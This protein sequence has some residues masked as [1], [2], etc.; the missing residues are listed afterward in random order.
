MGRRVRALGPIL[1]LV[2]VAAG[3]CTDAPT[4]SEAAWE[5]VPL[6]GPGR[7]VTLTGTPE[8]LL[9]GRYDEDAR[10]RASLHE[11]RADGSSGQVEMDT[12]WEWAGREAEL[13]SV[14]SGP[15]GTVA[16]G[17]HRAGAHGNVRWTVWSGDRRRV[18]EQPQPFETFGGWDAGGL[19][20]VAISRPGPMIL[21][22]RVSTSKQGLD[23]AVWQP[24]GE[25]WVMAPRP[26]STLRATADRQPSPGAVA[27][28][29][30]GY[31]AVGWVTELEP[32]IR[33]VAVAWTARSPGGPW[34]EIGL[35]AEGAGIARAGAVACAADHCVV[36]GRRDDDVMVWRVPLT[37]GTPGEASTGT[38][39]AA[40]ALRT[41]SPTLAVVAGRVD[42]AAYGEGETT[43]VVRLAAEPGATDLPGRLVAMAAEP[44]GAVV[45]ATT[46]GSGTSRA[47]RSTR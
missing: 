35:P 44:S 37:D 27:A 18:V 31:L 46:D 10:E 2:V 20:G 39:V 17:G 30:D 41:Q 43:R 25:R 15:T 33:D 6:P 3:G 9:V 34:R 23:V 38:T 16:L 1:A 4:Q 5:P 7:V 28:L 32:S 45:L 47:W 40:G 13:S 21:G 11:L 8:G 22:T 12:L 29:P 24:R 26:G 42:T 14:A 19:T 36:A